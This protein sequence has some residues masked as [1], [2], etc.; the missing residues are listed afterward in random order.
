MNCWKTINLNRQF[1][2]N[3]IYLLSLLVGML[4]FI[5][6]FLVFS[7]VHQ[8]GN[9]QDHGL[10][11][12]L[13]GLLVLPTVHK[14]MH[15][16]PLILT[17]KRVKIKWKINNR[18]FPTFSFRTKS[19]MSK[20]TSLFILLAPAVLITVPGIISSYLFID[21]Y[22]YFLIFS[23]VNLGLSFTD[24]LYANQVVRAPRKCLIENAKDGYDILI[25]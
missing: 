3:R 22:V 19:R 7:M 9:V 24:F 1:G 5:F 6:L 23:S 10:L 25:N 2:L 11:P 4:S 21:Y 17:N 8:T 14:L 15:I 18:I 12:L 20:Q 13:I 16:L